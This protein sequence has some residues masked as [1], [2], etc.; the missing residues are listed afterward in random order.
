MNETDKER[1][2]IAAVAKVMDAG[3]KKVY[4]NIDQKNGEVTVEGRA[5]DKEEANNNTDP[6]DDKDKENKEFSVAQQ[7]HDRAL[8]WGLVERKHIEHEGDCMAFTKE[9]GPL[10]EK[11]RP[12]KIIDMTEPVLDHL[13]INKH[14]TRSQLRRLGRRE[15]KTHDLAYLCKFLFGV[16]CANSKAGTELSTGGMGCSN[17]LTN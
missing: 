9:F 3:Y 6:Q 17:R 1:E 4:V 7:D 12:R 8:A 13:R 16:L 2:I 10:V 14:W 5:E 15:T 11:Y